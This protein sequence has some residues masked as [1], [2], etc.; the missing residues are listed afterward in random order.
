MALPATE[1]LQ[2]WQTLKFEIL[3][4]RGLLVSKL[5]AYGLLSGSNQSKIIKEA[6]GQI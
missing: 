4:Y 1:N 6:E 2:K 3:R 5:N